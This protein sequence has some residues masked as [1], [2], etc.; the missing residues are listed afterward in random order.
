MKL[1]SFPLSALLIGLL[2]SFNSVAKMYKCIDEEGAVTYSQT[3][4]ENDQTTDK[5]MGGNKQKKQQEDCKYAGQFANT[6]AGSMRSGADAEQTFNRYGGINAISKSSLAIINYVYTFKETPDVS[7]SRISSLTLARCN[8]NAF[9]KVRCEDFPAEFQASVLSCDEEQQQMLQREMLL[10]EQMQQQ[11]T[12]DNIIPAV[13][14]ESDSSSQ[15]PKSS[16]KQKQKQ[17]IADCKKG[18]DEQI[19]TIDKRMRQQHTAQ[20]GEQLRERRRQLQ[21]ARYTNCR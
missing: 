21:D 20:Q 12:P 14:T 17:R 10:R 6:I 1:I 11:N 19:A 18:Y 4:C 16:N 9:G 13:P 8:A 15:K 2:L 7:A 3:A 5:V